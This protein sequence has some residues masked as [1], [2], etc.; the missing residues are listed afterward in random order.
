MKT[1][2][3]YGDSNTWGTA[4]IG[5]PGGRYGP[6]ERWPGVLRAALGA[7]WSVVE[8]GLCGRTTVHPDPVDGH[9]LDGSAYLL[10][11]LLSHRPLDAV[12]VMLGSND[13]QMRFSVSPRDIAN[14]VGTLLTI[15]RKSEAGPAD[16][17]P[18]M[19][20]VCPP[21][22]RPGHGV[23]RD[24]DDLFTGGYEK[25]LRLA[26]C[27]A[28]VAQEHGAAF[29]N[30]GDVVESGAYDGVHLDIEAHA[31]LGHAVAKAVTELGC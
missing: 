26:P 16:G 7:G 11:C 24:F 29:L 10:P 30:A 25:S 2:L 6:D 20:V 3:C 5:R 9:W 15:I 22:V 4:T 28:A 23:R 14:G 1:V 8:E 18:K 19:L 13:L 17:V 12:V 31:A 21:P 27:Y